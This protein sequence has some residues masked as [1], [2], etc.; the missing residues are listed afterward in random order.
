M[1]ASFAC[2][3]I[4]SLVWTEARLDLDL[5]RDPAWLQAFAGAL[6]IPSAAAMLAVTALLV[7]RLGRRWSCVPAVVAVTGLT[8]LAAAVPGAWAAWSTNRFSQA[9]ASG[10]SSWR[11]HIG[12]SQEVLWPEGLAWTW[13]SVGRRS[14]LSISQLAGVVFS[15]EMTEEARRRAEAL[16]DVYSPAYWFGDMS[17]RRPDDSPIQLEDLRAVCRAPGVDFYVSPTDLGIAVATAEWPTRG[18]HV[19]LYDCASVRRGTGS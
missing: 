16:S 4:L 3:W 14:Y 2:I 9:E 10:Y 8:I 13:F 18:K 12:E 7:L 19:Y 1:F 15:E 6:K 17:S 11:A 5:G